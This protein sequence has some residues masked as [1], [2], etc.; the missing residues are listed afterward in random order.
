M[1]L[2]MNESK[3]LKYTAIVNAPSPLYEAGHFTFSFN[4]YVPLLLSSMLSNEHYS[5]IV[6]PLPSLRVLPPPLHTEIDIL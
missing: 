6:L 4:M 1:P 3:L 5:S 2:A